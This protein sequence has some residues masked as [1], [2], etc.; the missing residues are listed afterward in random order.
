[1]TLHIACPCCGAKQI[2]S[3]LDII[4]ESVEAS[5]YTTCQLQAY[6]SCMQANI[7][8]AFATLGHSPGPEILDAIAR[9]AAKKLAE[10][11]SQNISNLVYAFAKME[12]VPP[13]FLEQASQAARQLL[14]QFTP[15]VRQALLRFASL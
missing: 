8:W 6:N 9:E 10:F 5:Q 12:H 14:N 15:Q 11:T 13:G 4:C 7:A 1:M 3:G 2:C